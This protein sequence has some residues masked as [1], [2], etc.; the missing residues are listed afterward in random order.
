MTT[1]PATDAG[2]QPP[3]SRRRRAG[4]PPAGLVAIGVV[5]AIAVAYALWAGAA[6]LHQQP[7]VGTVSRYQVV[8]DTSV[9]YGLI[10]TGPAGVTVHCSVVARGDDYAIVGQDE[11]TLTL[12]STGEAH[13]SGSITTLRHA[14]N[15]EAGT[16]E[17]D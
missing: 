4:R 16:C 3:A 2:R 14:A 6:A 13:G 15:A 11:R 12:D 7:L 10:V 8:S 1:A 5:I 9:D 17:Q